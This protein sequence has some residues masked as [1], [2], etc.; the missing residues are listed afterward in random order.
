MYTAEF[1][2][3]G[4]SRAAENI[5]KISAEDRQFL[6]LM[7]RKCSKEGN[8]YKLPLLLWDPDA[9]YKLPLPL[10]DPYSPTTE[11]WLNWDQR[12]S[13]KGLS[14][15]NNITRITLVLWKIWSRRL[16]LK[17]HIHRQINRIKLGSFLVIGSIIPV[18]LVKFVLSLTVVQ[19]TMGFL[20]IKDYCLVLISPIR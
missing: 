11:G 18:N 16:M 14:R 12:I 4:T 10:W 17:S 15:M 6:D 9:Y 20:W 19:S 7:G 2:D 3:N 8:H 5:T 13:R 1:N